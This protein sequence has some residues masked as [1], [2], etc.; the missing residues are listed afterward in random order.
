MVCV[1]AASDTAEGPA[2]SSLKNRVAA[3][4]CASSITFTLAKGSCVRAKCLRKRNESVAWTISDRRLGENDKPHAFSI[5]RQLALSMW[6]SESREVVST[7]H[8]VGAR[9]DKKAHS[10]CVMRVVP[11]FLCGL[12][13]CLA[14]KVASEAG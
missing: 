7:S 9:K 10:I 12:E 13:F 6:R 5:R 8:S 14:V 1:D 4:S 2:N 11:Q 3:L